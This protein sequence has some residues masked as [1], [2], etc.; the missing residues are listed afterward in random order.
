MDEQNKQIDKIEEEIVDAEVVDEP[1][2]EPTS[3]KSDQYLIIDRAIKERIA[4]VD[5]L[6]EEIRPHKE[7][8]DLTLENDQNYSEKFQDSKKAS[9]ELM[10][11]KKDIMNR[12]QVKQI[13]SKIK[14]LRDELKETQEALSDYLREYQRMTGSNQFEGTDGELRTIVFSAKLIRKTSLED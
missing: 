3:D 12:P 2:D 11:V 1:T 9:K 4:R 7:M 6:K 5:K 13:V 14:E 10:I 8:L